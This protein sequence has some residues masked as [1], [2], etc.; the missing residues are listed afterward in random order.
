MEPLFKEPPD[1]Y[2]N[3]SFNVKPVKRRGK[4]VVK[5]DPAPFTMPQAP[6]KVDAM[7][8]DALG[9]WRFIK[10]VDDEVIREFTRGTE[11]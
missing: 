1:F 11:L 2:A 8:G 4:Y 7:L 10:S 6:D 5:K 9:S 3:A